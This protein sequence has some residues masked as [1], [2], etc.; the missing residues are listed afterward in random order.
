MV[1]AIAMIAFLTWLNTRGIVTGKTVQNFFSTT[2]VLSL[3][4]V[5]AI[6]FFATKAIGSWEINKEVFWNAS[7]VIS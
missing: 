6:G 5:I 3:L 1:V 4:G 2:K 7:Q